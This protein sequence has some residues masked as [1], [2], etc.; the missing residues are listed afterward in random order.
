MYIVA[1]DLFLAKN[2]YDSP[3]IIDFSLL[4]SQTAILTVLLVPIRVICII[5]LLLI[6]WCLASLGLYGLS[7]E[8]LKRKP[9]VSGW[10]G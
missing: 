5:V 9:I 4:T 2:V 7:K 10:R 1:N 3:L 6:A 8:D